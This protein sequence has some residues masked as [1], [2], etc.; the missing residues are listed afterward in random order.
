MTAVHASMA[1]SLD[2]FIA[3]PDDRVGNP[4]GDG[5]ERVHE[6]ML[7]TAAWLRSH[8]E[9]GGERSVDSDVVDEWFD[10]SGAVVLGRRMFDHGEGPWGDEPPYHKPAFVVTQR[11]REVLV[12]GETTFTFVTR[13]TWRRSSSAAESA[14]S[15]AP[16]SKG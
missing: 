9:E 2:G 1:M 4:L 13:S 15:T 14:S 5:G 7:K 12:K 16:G 11:P 8:G 3:G 10:R 6:W